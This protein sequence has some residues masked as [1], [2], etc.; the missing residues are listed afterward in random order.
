[1]KKLDTDSAAVKG[2]LIGGLVGVGALTVFLA[3]RKDKPLGSIGETISHV[4][5]VLEDHN[6][7]APA[8]I[9]AM[10][11]K[12]HKHENTLIDVV[13]WVATGINLW[14]KFKG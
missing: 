10:G 7:E 5:E 14:N 4:G 6:I 2:A 8:P 11:K 12:L 3:L 9:K 13:D 1:M